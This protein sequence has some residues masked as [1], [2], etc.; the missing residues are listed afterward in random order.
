MPLPLNPPVGCRSGPGVL[1][2]TIKQC[3]EGKIAIPLVPSRG[4]DDIA[5]GGLHDHRPRILL[6]RPPQVSAEAALHGLEI[7]RAADST[8]LDHDPGVLV[9]VG[10]AVGSQHVLLARV[11][12]AGVDVAV[13]EDS[14]GVAEDEVDGANDDAA[15]EELAV[16]VDV[17]CV[18]VG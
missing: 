15:V 13:L 10:P 4:V 7:R 9:R 11:G 3:V 6:P 17:Q 1:M 5:Y 18:L 14:G 16:G 12:S 2:L 8:F